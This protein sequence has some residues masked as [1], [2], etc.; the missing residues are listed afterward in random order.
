M[1]SLLHGLTVLA[2]IA[3]ADTGFGQLSLGIGNVGL[4]LGSNAS[5][6]YSY[7]YPAYSYPA[8]YSYPTYN[9]YPA[10][11]YGYNSWGAP[12]YAPSYGYGYA[13]PG[14]YGY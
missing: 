3:M 9:S 7:G 1:K 6:G 11:N 14:Y 10:Y 8:Y 13:Y 4:N 12:A 5:Y 2:L